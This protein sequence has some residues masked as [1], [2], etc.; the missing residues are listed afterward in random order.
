MDAL[1]AEMEVQVA[2]LVDTV[3]G[4]H[5]R[6]CDLDVISEAACGDKNYHA[7]GTI[8]P[9]PQCNVGVQEI[10]KC[11]ISCSLIKDYTVSTVNVKGV[12]QRD[13]PNLNTLIKETICWTRLLDETFLA[14]DA[15]H[16]AN[17]SF[18]TH[19]DRPPWSY[20]GHEST[21]LMRSFPGGCALSISLQCRQTL[22]IKHRS[23]AWPSRVAAASRS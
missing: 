6:R 18:P 15:A 11:G 13:Q 19:A 3:E 23:T 14:H 4:A 8:L 20:F 5:A 9:N 1:L 16:A 12:A 7:C 21:G 22:T 10:P 2:A 17:A